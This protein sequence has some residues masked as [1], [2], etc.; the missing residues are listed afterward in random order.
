[1]RRIVRVPL[2]LLSVV[3]MSLLLEEGFVYKGLVWSSDLACRIL[4]EGRVPRYSE[5][6]LFILGRWGS[7]LWFVVVLVSVIACVPKRSAWG[8]LLVALVAFEAVLCTAAG[9]ALLKVSV[10]QADCISVL[11]ARSVEH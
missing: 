9:V 6:F 7:P 10:F 4:R 8:S 1:M 3:W 2:A 11:G 5:A